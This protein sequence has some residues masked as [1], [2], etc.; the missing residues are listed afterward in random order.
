[1]A[2]KISVIDGED[3]ILLPTLY[4]LP[5]LHIRPYKSRFI[6]NSSSCTTT[7]L[8]LLLT[9]CLTA[10]KSHAIKCCEIVYVRKGK[11]LI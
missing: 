9:S 8:F 5:K 3:H 1:M 11:N 2:A 4:W 7:E 6:D 10:I